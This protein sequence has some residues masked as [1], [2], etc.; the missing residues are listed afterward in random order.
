MEGD[1]RDI[2]HQPAEELPQ[3]TMITLFRTL[4]SLVMPWPG[5][6]STYLCIYSVRRA[7]V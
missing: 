5:W 3:F 7:A 1:G 4:Q 6:I 2:Y